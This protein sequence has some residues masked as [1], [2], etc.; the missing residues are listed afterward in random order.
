MRMPYL[1]YSNHHGPLLFCRDKD[2][3]TSFDW[4][5]DQNGVSVHN[6]SMVTRSRVYSNGS[7][8]DQDM[9]WGADR[10]SQLP[11]VKSPRLKAD[12]D[13]DMHPL[14]FSHV[15]S[16]LLGSCLYKLKLSPQ[17]ISCLLTLELGLLKYFKHLVNSL[18]Y[19]SVLDW[20]M[21]ISDLDSHLSDFLWFT[22]S[23][24]L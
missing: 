20:N 4:G 13:D 23:C 15:L 11:T 7:W 2:A 8:R 5:S 21:V 3:L 22:I 14:G 18:G 9:W 17:M 16:F 19:L 12:P 1:M 6:T 24:T 10:L